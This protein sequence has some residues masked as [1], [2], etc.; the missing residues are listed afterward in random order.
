V[1]AKALALP[2]EKSV[3]DGPGLAQ[4][5]AMTA[6]STPPGCFRGEKVGWGVFLNGGG[7]RAALCFGLS[8]EVLE[9]IRRQLGVAHRML[10][11][12]VAEPSL[13]RPRVVTGVCQ[14]IPAGVAQHVRE[15]RKG[16]TGTLA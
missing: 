4:I 3:P 5:D 1:K 8:P 9:P 2:G 13:Q 14:C 16:H 10:D 11:V 6:R 15:D 12:L 7:S